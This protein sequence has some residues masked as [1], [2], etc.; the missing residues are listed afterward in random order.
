MKTNLIKRLIKPSSGR[1]KSHGPMMRLSACLGDNIS[2]FITIMMALTLP[3]VQAL[4]LDISYSGRLQEDSGKSIEGPLDFTVKFYNDPNNGDVIGPT[5]K[6]ANTELR[7]GVFQ[8]GLSLDNIQ[9]TALFGD[10]S[11]AVYIELE[12]GG[13]IY[14][15]Q[16]FTAVPFALR[17]PVDTQKLNYTNDGK[18][19]IESVDLNQ[20]SG[21]TAALAAKAD[22]S[23]VSS[24]S[25]K[26]SNNLSDLASPSVARTNLGLG[27]LATASTVGS[28]EITDASITNADINAAA[29]IADTKLATIATPG[30]V[31]GS[32]ITSGTIGGSTVIATSGQL[33]STG[34]IRVAGSGITA[35]ELRFGDNDDSNYV[36]FKAPGVVAG[37]KIWTLPAADGAS[38]QVLRTDGAGI[39]SWITPGGG[40]NMLGSANL[41]DLANAGTA[42]TNLGLGGLA[43]LSNVGST[44]ITDASIMNADI[45]ASAAIATSKLSGAVTSI[46]GHGLGSLATL[47]NVGSTE[48]TNDSIMNTDI[49]ASAAIA[50][51]KLSGA[52]T[53]IAGHGLGSLATLS[54]VG[55][56]E[57]TNDSIMN[58]DI[59]AS[60]AIATSKLS[61]AVTS[62]T[63]HGLGSLATLSNVGSAEITND[64]IVDADINASAAIAD[65]KLATITTAGKVSGSAITSGT[66]AGSTVVATSGQLSSTGNIRV[67]GTGTTATDLRFGDND[68][69]NYVGFKAP[70]SVSTDQ[71]WTLPASDGTSGQILRTNG[72]GT[73]SWVSAGGAGALVAASNLSDLANATTARTNLGLG[74]LA[75]LGAVGSTEITDASIM[76]A[77][78][79]AAAAIATSKLS[80]AVT[81]ITGHGLGSL[82]TLSNVGSTEITNDSIMN[83]D[84][85]TSAAIATSKLSG[86]V[87]SITGHGLGG[88]ATLGAVGSTE[89]TN[90]SIMNTDIN[91]AAAIATSKLS[92][93]VTSITGHGLGSL[94]TLSNVGSAEI[95]DL[96]IMNADINASA[97]IADTKLATITTAGKVSGSAITSGTIGG[98]TVVATSGQL[99]S[100]G[101]I[102]VAGT[103]TTATDLRFG[104][105]DDSNYVGFKAPASVTT[106]QIWTLPA[107]DGTSGQILRTNGTGTL[108]WVSAGGAGALVAASNLSD[109]ANATTART[110]LGLGSLA[111]LSAVGSTEITDASIMNADINASAAIATSKLSGAVTSITGHGLG[112]LATLSNVGSTEITNDSI[113]NT[114][115]NASAAIAT[116][117]LSGAVTSIT[118]HGLGTLA[119]ASAVSGGTAGT[120]TDDDH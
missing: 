116:S 7:D 114:D 119:T 42:R 100:T 80:G 24:S 33:S 5:L 9:I 105:N 76:N 26:M 37:D 117:K 35:T 96:S 44:E 56:T 8:L 12:A 41:S 66:I 48:I 46:T 118:G 51:S 21:L 34:N 60:A 20:I 74:S 65:T 73:L 3:A 40:G 82:A 89:I 2:A 72:T 85:N 111:T 78:I 22:A 11:K 4:A 106:D 61:G 110:N 101:N 107:S 103:G 90:D 57:I 108:S 47:S 63:G 15:R 50:T 10:G 87:T 84:I 17:I 86:A 19:T 1:V 112:T 99:S 53:S 94:A 69:S 71:I 95:T 25:V 36:G 54:N 31:S 39:L 113:M 27:T 45:N 67:A 59:N 109:L 88:L 93:A 30:K 64:S 115:I 55:S 58:T 38:G 6:L 68:D 32:A 79:N 97:A 23:A 18:L 43:T 104:D 120:I 13:K 102:R 28:A 75:T 70:A 62:I 14:P 77:D 16:R 83:T 52:V 81:S 49:N 98:S 92:G 29:A 91:T